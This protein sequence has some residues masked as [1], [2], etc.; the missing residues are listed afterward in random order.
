MHLQTGLIVKNAP[1]QSYLTETYLGDCLYQLLSTRSHLP[2]LNDYS[3]LTK[4]VTKKPIHLGHFAS[5]QYYL[6]QFH[7]V[8]FMD[9]GMARIAKVIR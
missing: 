5:M 3:V 2:P 1:L 9:G 6:P 7:T 4:L 8:L